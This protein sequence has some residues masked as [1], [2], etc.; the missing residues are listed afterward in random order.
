MLNIRVHFVTDCKSSFINIAELQISV[1]IQY[2]VIEKSDSFD[3]TTRYWND[4]QVARNAFSTR[5]SK[6][7]TVFTRSEFLCRGSPPRELL[8]SANPNS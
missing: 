1:E 3:A 5:K 2:L 8:R 4:S 7:P 6:T